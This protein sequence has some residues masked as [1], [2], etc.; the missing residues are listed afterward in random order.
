M[1]NMGVTRSRLFRRWGARH[2]WV[3]SFSQ[4]TVFASA[5]VENLVI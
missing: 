2:T 1:D 3:I 5:P 4:F